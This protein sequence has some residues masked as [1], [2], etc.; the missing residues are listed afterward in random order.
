MKNGKIF[1]HKNITLIKKYLICDCFVINNQYILEM[2]SYT[3][4]VR[5]PRIPIIPIQQLNNR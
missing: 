5:I 1:L 4:Q 3:Q 2:F